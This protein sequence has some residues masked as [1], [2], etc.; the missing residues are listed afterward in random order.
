MAEPQ[1]ITKRKKVK[2]EVVETRYRVDADFIPQ[3][4]NEICAEFIE[5]YCVAHNEIAWLLDTVNKTSYQVVRNAGKSDEYTETVNC[6]N[7][8]FPMLRKDFITKFFSS[9]GA[10]SDKVSWKDKL[11]AKYKK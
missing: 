1:Y 5:N 6:D 7:Y 10:K 3:E 2:G 4:A 9:L 8:P 11:N